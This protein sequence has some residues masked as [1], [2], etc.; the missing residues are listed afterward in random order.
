MTNI[1]LPISDLMYTVDRPVA[2]DVV[3]Q[4]M[5]ITQISSK[6]PIRL[7][8]DE[9]KGL[10]KNTTLNEDTSQWNKYPFDDMLTIEV[11]EDFD[12]DRMLSTQVKN[13]ENLFIFRDAKL[14]VGIKPVYAAA[15]VTIT[16]KYRGSDKNKANTWRNS[17]RT[18][19]SMGRDINLHNINYSYQIPEES[20]FILKEIHR[21]RELQEGYG[22]TFDEYFSTRITNKANTV[23]NLNGNKI[24]WVVTEIQSRIQGVFDFQT[25]GVP[26]KAEKEGDSAAYTTTFVYKF[27]YDKPIHLNMVYPVM[28][29]NK[30]LGKKYRFT[31]LPYK[32]EDRPLNFTQTG[33][34]FSKFEE[35]AQILNYYGN[36]GLSIP[37]FDYD[38]QPNSIPTSTAKVLTALSAIS[39]HDK[40]TL[41]NLNDLGNFKLEQSILDFIKH[42]RLYIPKTFGSIFCLHLYKNNDLQESGSLV[43]DENLNV[44]SITDLDVRQTYRVRL[45]LFVNISTLRKDVLSR[46]KEYARTH[47][48]FI[49]RLAKAIN[50][51]LKDIGSHPDID[52]PYLN[53]NDLIK[54]GVNTNPLVFN[55][56][57][58]ASSNYDLNQVSQSLVSY[59]F[60]ISDSIQNMQGN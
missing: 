41:F 2:F 33:V 20:I 39:S 37:E 47:P 35:C 3:R 51:I 18:N 17:I 25:Q 10:Q 43:I 46:L 27:T 45:G 21:L 14:G 23:S 60:I 6:T 16:V 12:P 22:D 48:E 36:K 54:I 19:V 50:A 55:T 53:E 34:A 57:Y 32:L 7:F 28:I 44:T 42:E 4:L 15:N 24:D 29:H 38:F 1:V 26:D 31:E 52:R 11:S 8:G 30:L 5:D 40:R 56:L 9:T 59:L 58:P 13:P 49:I